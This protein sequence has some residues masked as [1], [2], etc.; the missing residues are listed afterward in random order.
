MGQRLVLGA[1]GLPEPETGLYFL[2]YAARSDANKQN[3]FGYADFEE[4]SKIGVAVSR[5][6]EGPFHNIAATRSTGTRTT[7]TTTTST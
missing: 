5:S 4:P 1:G 7:R 6:P 3:W 2:F